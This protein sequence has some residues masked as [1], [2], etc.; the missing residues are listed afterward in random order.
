[1]Q[2]H[3]TTVACQ[4]IWNIEH[5]WVIFINTFLYMW[6]K[7][8]A[9]ASIARGGVGAGWGRGMGGVG[10][11]EM[12]RGMKRMVTREGPIR[13]AVRAGG[14]PAAAAVAGETSAWRDRRG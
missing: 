7:L 4:K 14:G 3:F 12:V 10:A 13:G 9:L 5:G 1:M 11:G 2:S 6:F 8:G